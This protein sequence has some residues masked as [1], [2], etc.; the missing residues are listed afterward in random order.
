MTA[1][2]LHVINGEFYAGAERVQDLLAAAL[3]PMGYACDFICLKKGK[4]EGK[5][6]EV[7][8]CRSSAVH[9]VER[10]ARFDWRAVRQIRSILVGGG[11]DLVHTH[12]VPGAVAA[13][14]A[15][16]AAGVPLIHHVHS[17]TR[18]D[19][20]DAGRNRI[21]AFAEEVFV[22]PA[23]SRVI[24]VSN[25][26]R[27]Y[28]L[29]V[30]VPPGR[31]TVVPNGVPPSG[32]RPVWRMPEGEWTVGVVALF[33]F[34]KGL[35][36]LMRAIARLRAAGV[37]VRLRVV[38]GFENPEYERVIRELERTLGLRGVIEW[39]GFTCDVPA[40]IAGFSIFALPSL[41]GE[42]LPMVLL[43]A[44]AAGL[45]VVA[46]DV[47]G[48]SQVI[49]GPRTGVL[50]APDDEL[51]LSEGIASV[52]SRGAAAGDLAQ[53]AWRRQRAAF[54]DASMARSVAGIYGA[55]LA[56]RARPP[57]MPRAPA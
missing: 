26:I 28:L 33:R 18:R 56:G 51:S 46:T 25:S 17:P 38:G 1:R 15:G 44:M 47:E 45:P 39:T 53:A 48:V 7:R 19:T 22:L 23:A 55:T 37:P 16:L 8:T 50:V 10:R 3:P 2:V 27:E 14:I 6:G 36:V 5:F 35:H 40:A 20:I 52:V 13:R 12:T 4:L 31:I 43:E 54:S 21:N 41:L 57:A 34:R 30:G 32:S 11:Y 9:E 29:E 24:A 49:D 42:G